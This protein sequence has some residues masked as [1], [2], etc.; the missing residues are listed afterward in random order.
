[1]SISRSFAK[2]H[3]RKSDS[4]HYLLEE[5]ESKTAL[6]S[7]ASKD[8]HEVV[9]CSL[10]TNFAVLPQMARNPSMWLA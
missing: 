3:R 7:T 5:D 9:S 4:K 8:F 6:S 2:E 10:L 1:M